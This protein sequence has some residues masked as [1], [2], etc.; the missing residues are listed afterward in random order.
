[1]EQLKNYRNRDFQ[2]LHSTFVFK[3]L[4]RGFCLSHSI[5]ELYQLAYELA[6]TE[7]KQQ[8]QIHFGGSLLQK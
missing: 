4:E 3:L 6:I 7:W 1:M 2:K 5:P 8:Q